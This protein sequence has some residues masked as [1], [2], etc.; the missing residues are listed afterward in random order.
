MTGTGSYITER[1]TTMIKPGGRAYEW[2]AAKG[3]CPEAPEA[4]EWLAA[5]GPISLNEAW[6]RCPN[7]DW[8]I[9]TL[10]HVCPISAEA[11][12]RNARLFAC[13]CVER[14]LLYGQEAGL[15]PSKHTWQ[16]IKMARQFAVGLA[17][18]E[19]LIAAWTAAWT[20]VKSAWSVRD[21]SRNIIWN[22]A[23]PVRDTVWAAGAAAR[24]AVWAA[25]DTAGVVAK[26]AEQRWQAKRLREYFKPMGE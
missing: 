8:L 13:D 6:M 22:T 14:A 21:P 9:W 3:V 23:W 2:A 4:L 12:S 25:Q 11:H 19:D 5:Q 17:T 15:K 18:E 1:R 16:M 20:A 7:V 24:D 10:A 26:A